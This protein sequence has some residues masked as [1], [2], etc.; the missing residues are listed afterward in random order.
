[1]IAAPTELVDTAPHG[2]AAQRRAAPVVPLPDLQ[3]PRSHHRL[4]E[5]AA[6]KPAQIELPWRV[7]FTA[8]MLPRLGAMA[9]VEARL[10]MERRAIEILDEGDEGF[11]PVTLEVGGARSRPGLT[12]PLNTAPRQKEPAPVASGRNCHVVSP[13]ENTTSPEMHWHVVPGGRR[14]MTPFN[15]FH[16]A[17]SPARRERRGPAEE[18]AS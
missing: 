14:S 2:L 6:L 11:G 5:S 15:A 9:A 18:A 17:S 1:M 13:S 4:H 16:R 8:Q 7:P 3:S 12:M 10:V